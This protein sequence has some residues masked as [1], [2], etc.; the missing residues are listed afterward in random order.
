MINLSNILKLLEQEYCTRIS[1]EPLHEAFEDCEDLKLTPEQPLHSSAFCRKK[2]LLDQNRSCAANKE[3]SVKIASLGRTF[4]GC[5]PFGVREF[6]QPVLLQGK[7]AAVCYFTLLSGTA[8]LSVLREKGKFL[9]EFIRMAI[10]N[11]CANHSGQDP[12]KNSSEYY[13]RKCLYFLDL[14]YMENIAEAD[15]AEH[16]GLNCTYLSS[17]FRKIMGKTFRQVL[18]E[19]RIHEAKIYLRLHRNLHI[20]YIAHLC[21]FSDSNYFS[22]VFRR[23]TGFTPKSYRCG[24]SDV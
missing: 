9:A 24:K 12:R 18:T 13:K 15:L 11:H 21:G 20:T 14:H 17:L 22:A 16:L 10:L 1:I 6:V 3:R 4:T 5:C 8:E 7:L 2:K 23:C 19:R